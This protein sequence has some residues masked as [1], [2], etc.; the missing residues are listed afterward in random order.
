MAK[1]TGTVRCL[2]IA[3]SFGFITI[4]EDTGGSETLIIWWFPGT[5]AGL[6]QNL[7]AFTRILHS[8]WVSQLRDAQANNLTVEI[9]HPDGSAEIESVRLGKL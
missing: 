7:T 4:D 5:G 2:Q 8:M 3:E 1:T 6:P 9:L